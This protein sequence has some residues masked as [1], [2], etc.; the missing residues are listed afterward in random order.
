MHFLLDG[1]LHIPFKP[2]LGVL[3]PISMLNQSNFQA[4]QALM[5]ADGGAPLKIVAAQFCFC[6]AFA[7]IDSAW[8][9]A[10]VSCITPAIL[11]C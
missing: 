5:S 1:C 11:S 2:E 9:I 3:P 4:I 6:L 10:R 7:L 8:S